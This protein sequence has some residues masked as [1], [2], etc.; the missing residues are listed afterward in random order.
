MSRCDLCCSVLNNLKSLWALLHHI[1]RTLKRSIIC[2]LTLKALNSKQK[3]GKAWVIEKASATYMNKNFHGVLIVRFILF[4]L[5]CVTCLFIKYII[6][7]TCLYLVKYE[8]VPGISSARIFLRQ[9]VQCLQTD[10]TDVNNNKK[11]SLNWEKFR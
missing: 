10:I 2:K 3:I 6:I 9:N 1:I 5:F 4:Y 7:G 11:Y 8:I